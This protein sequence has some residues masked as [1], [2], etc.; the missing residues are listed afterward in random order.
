MTTLFLSSL[1]SRRVA[2]ELSTPFS[3][4]GATALSTP[5]GVAAPLLP[6]V[7]APV[8]LGFRDLLHSALVSGRLCQVRAAHHCSFLVSVLELLTGN[9][10]MLGSKKQRVVKVV[11]DA[12]LATAGL[13][14]GQILEARTRTSPPAT[15]LSPLPPL[16]LRA[17]KLAIDWAA[18]VVSPCYAASGGRK[19]IVLSSSLRKALPKPVARFPLGQGLG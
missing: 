16:L 17:P 18:F 7:A 6:V 9:L 19:N 12:W 3:R 14:G 11:M 2:T 5:P 1:R 13:R 4:R 8:C 15:P 10:P